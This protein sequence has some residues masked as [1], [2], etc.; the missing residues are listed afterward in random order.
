MQHWLIQSRDQVTAC[1][2]Y[3]ITKTK[4]KINLDWS[5]D[6]AKY[7]L[8]WT[9]TSVQSDRH[10]HGFP[11]T[12]QWIFSKHFG[13]IYDRFLSMFRFKLCTNAATAVKPTA[14]KHITA[15]HGEPWLRE[16]TFPHTHVFVIFLVWH[17][18]FVCVIIFFFESLF[19]FFYYNFLFNWE[20]VPFPLFCFCVFLQLRV[21]IGI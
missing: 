7:R 1:T 5:G 4:F 18:F 16:N 19:L 14:T 20:H 3:I 10:G 11:P 13:A 8:R 21:N 2:F 17:F 6:V 12:T 9:F 15:G